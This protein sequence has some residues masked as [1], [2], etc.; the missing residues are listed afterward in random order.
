VSIAQ[1]YTPSQQ[2]WGKITS[3]KPQ[4]LSRAD[5]EL[6]AFRLGCSVESAR[7]AIELGLI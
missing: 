7:R 1:A 3:K 6:T 5:L 4:R 2:F